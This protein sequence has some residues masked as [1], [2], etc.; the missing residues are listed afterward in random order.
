M[1]NINTSFI[2]YNNI[3]I[4]KED[5]QETIGK[6]VITDNSLNPF[7]IVH[8]GLIFSLG[9]TVMGVHA[10]ILGGKSLTLN[11]SIN[12]LK[13]STG[14]FLIAKS[15]VIKKGHK[16]CILNTNIYDS[17]DVLIAIMNST[18]FYI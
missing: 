9:D 14:S 18:Y 10:N 16:T 5:K 8:G 17:N 15:T 12:Y 2:K 4:I 1:Q 11:A 3:E 7:G 6:C 13:P